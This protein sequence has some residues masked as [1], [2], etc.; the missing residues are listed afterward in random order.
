MSTMLIF[1]RIPPVSMTVTKSWQWP[2]IM[3]HARNHV[4]HSD[5]DTL[6]F[7]QPCRLN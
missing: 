5:R 4:I 7:L 6:I 1:L 3:A 2:I